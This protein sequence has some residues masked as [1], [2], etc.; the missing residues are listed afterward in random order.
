[1]LLTDLFAHVPFCL[2]ENVQQAEEIEPGAPYG[3]GNIPLGLF[4]F[5]QMLHHKEKLTVLY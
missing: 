3:S 5:K 2:L 1:M 4:F